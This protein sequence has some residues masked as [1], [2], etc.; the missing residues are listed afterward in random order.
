MQQ[1][2]IAPSCR[3]SYVRPAG[4]RRRK[5]WLGTGP[6]QRSP[7]ATTGGADSILSR[8]LKHDDQSLSTSDT[9]AR[10]CCR[11]LEL[12]LKEL[13]KAEREVV[14]KERRAA[15][16]AVEASKVNFSFGF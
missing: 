5:R 9:T 4:A 11:V 15:E 1:H 16:A 3:N 13:Q 10:P 6:A 8:C 14:E 12:A 2:C 7:A